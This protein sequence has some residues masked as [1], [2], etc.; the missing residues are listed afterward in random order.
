MSSLGGDVNCGWVGHGG[1]GRGRICGV[2]PE[3]ASRV[4]AG[5]STKIGEGYDN[6]IRG[7]HDIW[8]E[9]GYDYGVFNGS[10][11]VDCRKDEGSNFIFW[12]QVFLSTRA[13]GGGCFELCSLNNGEYYIPIAWV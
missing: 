12:V 4:E 5:R 8:V 10:I 11:R 13:R 6:G 1:P 9:G 7:G 3:N 2:M